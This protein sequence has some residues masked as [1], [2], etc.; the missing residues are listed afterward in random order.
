MCNV[1]KMRITDMF[2]QGSVYASIGMSYSEEI[3]YPQ[4][5]RETFWHE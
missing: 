5:T 3:I 4:G 1:K 2:E